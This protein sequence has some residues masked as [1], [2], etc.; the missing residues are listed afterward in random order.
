MTLRNRLGTHNDDALRERESTE[1]NEQ[2]GDKGELVT[3]PPRNN[4]AQEIIKFP[5]NS[6]ME[7]CEVCGGSFKKGRGL[8]IHQGKT[9][10]KSV[11]ENR[12]SKSKAGG[13]QDS[14]H[15]GTTISTFLNRPTQF[16]SEASKG[17]LKDSKSDQARE[18]CK[19]PEEG[20]EKILKDKRKLGKKH[21][22]NVEISSVDIRQF[23][24]KCERR[25]T[26]VFKKSNQPIEQD[27]QNN[28]LET[29]IPP[30]N[31]SFED[32]YK[33]LSLE[34]NTGNR[35]DIL[36]RHNIPMSREDYRSLSGKNWLNDNILNEYIH[37]VK[38]RN[39][40]E[41]LTKVSTLD[42]FA[43]VRLENN[44]EDGYETIKNQTKDD[45]TESDIVLVPIH[46]DDHW[47]LISVVIKERKIEY[48]DSILST[49][50]YS[51]APKV[52][53]MF[54]NRYFEEK[55]KQ[56][57]FKV[58]VKKDAPVQ[59]NGHDCGI[60]VCLE[61]EE[62]ARVGYV[63][64]QFDTSN[65]RRKIMINIFKGNLNRYEQN[66]LE[67]FLVKASQRKENEN[68]IRETQSNK[69][70]KN[71]VKSGFH[72]KSAK[73]KEV[74][75][76]S[77]K[78]PI[79]WPKAN[80]KDW[81]LLDKDLTALLKIKYLTA[82]KKSESHPIIIY[83]M[84]R[85]RFGVRE[86]NGG[87]K[88]CGPS[89][90]QLKCA[91]LRRE[92]NELKNA[93]KVASASEQ[94]AIQEVNS[95]KLRQ[96]RLAK[97]A[98]SI[99]KHRKKFSANCK[100]FLN[101]P[102]KFSR[103]VI[104]PKPKGRLESS[105]EEIEAHLKKAHSNQGSPDDR[106]LLEDL[107]QFSEPEYRF[108]DEVPSFK[109][110]MLKLRKT[111]S[112]SAPGPNGIPYLVY[113][114]CPGVARELW[115]YIKELWK[116]NTIS[117][118]W[119][120][121][122]G[123]F[124]PKE[125]GA[126]TVDKFR[127]I[128]LLN[129]EGKL[130]FSLKADRITSFLLKNSLIDPSIQKGGIPGI[131]GCLEHTS[132]VSQA[133]RE[134]K[135][136]KKNLVVTW[137]D[138]ANAYGSI[139][140]DVIKHA[141]ENAHLPTRARDLIANYYKDLRIR[142]TTKD[143]TTEWQMVEKGIITGCTLSVVL[144]S[145]TMS[146]LVQSVK[147][148]TKGPKTSSGQRQVNSRLFMDDINT[149]TETVPQTNHLVT[150][151][152]QKMKW[153]GLDFRLVKCR[154]LVIYKGVV[155]NREIK[156]DGVAMQ[157]LKDIPAKYLGK[158]Y[159]QDLQEREQ[160]KQVEEQLKYD[161]KKI[162]KCKLPGRYKCWMVQHMLK[163]RIMWPLSIYNVPLSKVEDMQK[164]ITKSLKRWLKIPNSLS[165]TCFYSTTSRLRLPYSS[166]VEEFKLTKARNLLIFEDSVDPCISNANITVDGGRKA[167][168]PA[169]V[170]QA[171][172]RLQMQEIIGIPNKGR[173]GL[174]MRG[175]QY[176]SKSTKKGKRDLVVQEI[177]NKEEEV[178]KANMTSFSKQGA[179][180]RW[181]VPQKYLKQ[182]EIIK[183]SG[184][185]ISFLIKSVYDLL[186]TPANK[187][188]WFKTEDKCKLCGEE[189]TLQH[190]LAGCKVALHQGRYKWRHDKV[191]KK[192][193]ESI[194]K[195]IKI[196]KN[197]RVEIETGVQFI[198]EGEKKKEEAKTVR[199]NYFSIA[200]DWE[201]STDLENCLKIPKEVTFTNLRPDIIL[202][203]RSTKQF[204]MVELTV[205]SEERVEVSGELK[206]LKYE[207]I[208]QDARLNGWGVRVWAVEV[209]CR[210]FPASSMASFLREIGYQ[211]AQ[212]K[213]TLEV[214]G[215]EAENASHSLWKASFFEKWGNK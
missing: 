57:G 215:K 115:L 207:E 159:S 35:K 59:R 81:E 109:E 78:A 100:Q 173:E 158:K 69:F 31:K 60:F 36:S 162:D 44:F 161:L 170:K 138:I 9:K 64:K 95:A 24:K 46:K 204:G 174:G 56:A 99:R 4:M 91:K 201:M 187:N 206:R 80:S 166:I 211:G 72:K 148:E 76:K 38:E 30:I 126:K 87:N 84:C 179:Q 132:L 13:P 139:P 123:V 88:K 184:A 137:L 97:R 61:A 203:S 192:I 47:T 45:L 150:K 43:F 175:R 212:K 194:E 190:I 189:G 94:E 55:H 171:K 112:K 111:R 124:I 105:K 133:I 154:S 131:S 20:K 152:S 135:K 41:N 145:L 176:Y 2:G 205:P 83:E 134:A 42:S 120:E 168:T 185:R 178:R 3:L 101:Q 82:E 103:E 50:N 209:G 54:F 85:E 119:R 25:V 73:N 163:P 107:H 58:D 106:Q 160:I 17:G 114:R 180:L 7:S 34:L 172:S 11:L 67:D 118:S 52:F 128:S 10:C 51:K 8:K 79:N 155:Q 191:L 102:Y 196:N 199:G 27:S 32:G 167:D 62:I 127:T 186:P 143:C 117:N 197:A 96:L 156:I 149:M 63:R 92:I 23:G 40:Q 93:Y 165:N 77:K 14:H 74:I 136:E 18:S 125:E 113:K 144:F 90:R 75:E 141:L 208:A 214:I 169:E 68:V 65:A 86:K 29:A 122:E 33:K 153:A 66:N 202:I 48:Y 16:L 213:K 142:F 21:N 146:W 98:E 1:S 28:R 53:R 164:K 121:A 147:N 15:S 200:K 6:E 130:F 140:H 157:S 19:K 129:V 39:K 151:L 193:A 110:F 108:E 188:K 183:T 71:S 12:K 70:L 181:E 195:R 89:K 182:N 210:G 104:A 177:R 5:K 37:L 198:R 22:F 116:R 26:G 49:R